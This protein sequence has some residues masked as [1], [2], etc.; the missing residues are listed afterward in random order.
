MNDK[1]KLILRSLLLTA[2]AS[3]LHQN[4]TAAENLETVLP[5]IKLPD[6][7]DKFIRGLARRSFKN[8]LTVRKNGDIS[9][10]ADHRSHRS[11]S[12]HSSHRSGNSGSHY[13]HTS[14]RSS[15]Y[16]GGGSSTTRSSGSSTS[17]SS[18]N[19]LY[20]APSPKKT[21]ANYVLG[22]RVLKKGLYGADMEELI[23]LLELNLYLRVGV[24]KKQNGYWLFNDDVR[25]ALMNFQKDA[26][27]SVTG[28]TDQQTITKLRTWKNQNTTI[29]LGVR[30][31]ALSEKGFDVD[32]LV[33]LLTA[34]GF[35]PDPSKLSKNGNHYIF[36]ADIKRA[37]ELFQAYNNLT[38]TGTTDIPTVTK[39]KALAK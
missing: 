3:F 18:V 9:V 26:S 13:S 19:S 5:D 31:L 34:A 39:L 32:E 38:V 37:L 17:R 36:T 8:V 11:H 33:R 28:T 35:A 23:N 14:H 7:G 24:P 25:N 1:S 4:A 22:D 27:L 10:I 15:S 21:I 16:S 29:Q 20:S 6:K 12:S 30:D 2:A